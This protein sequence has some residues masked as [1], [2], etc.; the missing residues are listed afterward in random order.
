MN[1]VSTPC[2]KVCVMDPASGLCRG[3]M[4]TLTEIASWGTMSETQ[5]LAVMA[6]LTG[7]AERVGGSVS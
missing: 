2:I 7:R 5:R 1:R 3:C 6:T 4:R